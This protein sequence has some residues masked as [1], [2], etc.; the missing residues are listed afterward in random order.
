MFPRQTHYFLRRAEQNGVSLRR[1]IA[2]KVLYWSQKIAG[3]EFFL[4]SFAIKNDKDMILFNVE[5][6]VLSIYSH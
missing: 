2:S 4:L 6:Y 3:G 5:K 1:R